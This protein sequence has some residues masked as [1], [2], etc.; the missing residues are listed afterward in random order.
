MALE[1][2]ERKASLGPICTPEK[3]APMV[4]TVGAVRR[5]RWQRCR[6]VRG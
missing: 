6:K 2:R 3:G 1:R 5:G 4:E